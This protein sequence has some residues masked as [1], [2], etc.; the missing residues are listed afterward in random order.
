[1][2][3][4]TAS[5]PRSECRRMSLRERPMSRDAGGDQRGGATR[6]GGEGGVEEHI[7]I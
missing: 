3:R 7:L 6:P 5:S 4:L 1:V 2:A